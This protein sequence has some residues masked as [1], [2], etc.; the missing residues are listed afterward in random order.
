[1]TTRASDPPAPERPAGARRPFLLVTGLA[2][3]GVLLAILAVVGLGYLLQ[4]C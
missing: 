2:R 3:L 1:M 4:R